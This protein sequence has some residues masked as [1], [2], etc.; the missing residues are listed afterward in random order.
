VI[1]RVEHIT[2]TL[3]LSR[4]G[5]VRAGIA[6][7]FDIGY[8]PDFC[9]VGK[10]SW[11]ISDRPTIT[12]TAAELAAP[13]LAL[14]GLGV[15]NVKVRF[16]SRSLDEPLDQMSAWADYVVPLLESH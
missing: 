4:Y 10:P 7:P 16:R 2:P 15:N 14:Q 11:D 1:A 5:V 13:I 12:G 8:L 3:A 6:G 9:Y